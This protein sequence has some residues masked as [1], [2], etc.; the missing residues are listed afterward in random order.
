MKLKCYNIQHSTKA[1][2]SFLIIF[3]PKNLESLE[4]VGHKEEKADS[5][6]LQVPLM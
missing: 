3:L 2:F 5:I 6:I 4:T 1:K